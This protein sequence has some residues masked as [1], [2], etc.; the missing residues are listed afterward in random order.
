VL[1]TQR[2]QFQQEDAMFESEG[3]V[4][5]NLIEIYRALGGGWA[6]EAAEP[7]PDPGVT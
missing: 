1:D 3:L 4:T 7:P 2:S 6:P 5:Q